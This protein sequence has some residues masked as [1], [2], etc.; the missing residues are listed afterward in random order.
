[1]IKGWLAQ[2]FHTLW[3]FWTFS[4]P[5][6]CAVF[7]ERNYVIDLKTERIGRA[8]VHL[9]EPNTDYLGCTCGKVFYQRPGTEEQNAAD[10]H[11]RRWH[12]RFKEHSHDD[13]GKNKM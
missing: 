1:M 5:G 3:H 2:F 13:C 6:H 10:E 9:L 12:T 8:K 11:V 7:I 4:N